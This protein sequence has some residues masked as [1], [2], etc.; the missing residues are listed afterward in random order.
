MLLHLWV[1]VDLEGHSP[2]VSVVGIRVDGVG[3]DSE[4]VRSNDGEG[5]AKATT[6]LVED[7]IGELL[8]IGVHGRTLS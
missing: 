1:R 5:S 8:G 4:L 3:D 6:N 2:Q 7:G